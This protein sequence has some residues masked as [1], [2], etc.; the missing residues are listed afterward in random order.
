VVLDTC[1]AHGH[2]FDADELAALADELVVE[3]REAAASAVVD[4]APYA[5]TKDN[6]HQVQAHIDRQKAIDDP[7]VEMLD[8]VSI[9]EQHPFMGRRK[10][11]SFRLSKVLAALFD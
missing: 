10:V 11:K 2:W 4:D 3:A 6:I 7:M 5:I 9:Y 8:T 1:A